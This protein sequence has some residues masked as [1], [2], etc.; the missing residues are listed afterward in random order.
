MEIL[1][2]KKVL[3]LGLGISGLAMA[4][5]CGRFGA[6]VTVVDTR[7]EPPQLK[8]LR[9]EL[10]HVK[11]IQHEFTPDL[12]ANISYNTLLLSPGIK[13]EGVSELRRVALSQGVEIGGELQLF[14]QALADLKLAEA[15]QPNILA[16][17]GTNGKTTVTSLT[18][19]LIERAGKSVSIAGNIGPSLLDTLGE[20]MDESRL[21]DVWVLE[22]SSFQLDDVKSFEPTAATILN[23]TQDHLDWHG[24]MQAYCK[25]KSKVFGL[26]SCMLLN[27]D[28]P[29]VM[30]MLPLESRSIK[31]R[32]Y[33]TFGADLPSRAGD[34]GLEFS[35]GVT[36]LVKA[37]SLEESG[38][39]RRIA[40]AQ[41]TSD[42]IYMQRLLPADALQIQGRH[43]MVNALAALALAEQAN[44][45][46]APMLYALREYRGEPHRVELVT[47]ICGVDYYDDSK[48]T[49]VGAT[50]AA[51]QG[52]GY[53]QRIV[54]ILGGESKGQDFSPLLKPVQQYARA[55]VLIGKDKSAIQIALKDITCPVIL[56]ESMADAVVCAAE[57]A[58]S[59]DA[60]LMSPACASFDMFDNYEHRGRVFCEVV[61]QLA[62]KKL[63]FLR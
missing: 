34:Y 19:R 17:T 41:Q 33:M 28:D 52:L 16:I 20:R 18:G 40:I 1:A 42:D 26:Q 10:P 50:V 49:N 37:M 2:H 3:V 7:T 27:R 43:N 12:I 21:P 30:G 54:L 58:R 38:T 15:Y 5:W 63:M 44:C 13:P 48:G 62:R 57:H 60:V 46:L 23:I 35:N 59:G 22:L 53:S 47:R 9:L 51:L 24:N 8:T 36:W 11:F 14:S 39:K 6:D 29:L 56:T 31:P 55:V 25:A 61:E 32:R 4:R 45:A